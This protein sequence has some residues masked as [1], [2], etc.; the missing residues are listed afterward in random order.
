MPHRADCCDGA[1]EYVSAAGCVDNCVDVGAEWRAEQQE[2]LRIA[3]EGAEL[4]K[5]YIE[6]GQAA[7][8]QRAAR[9]AE[10]KAKLAALEAEKEVALRVQES[11]EA[12]EEEE[13]TVA[14]ASTESDLYAALGIDTMSAE[15]LRNL[16]VAHVRNTNTSAELVSYLKEA[17]GEAAEAAKSPEDAAEDRRKEL[18]ERDEEGEEAGDTPATPATPTGVHWLDNE[19]AAKNHVRPEAAA[20][21]ESVEAVE[22]SI[23]DVETE[24]TKLEASDKHDYGPNEEF[25]NLADHCYELGVAQYTYKVC[26]FGSAK[27]DHTSLGTFEG[28]EDGYKRMAFKNGQHC[29]NGPSRSMT[30]TFKCGLEEAILSVDEPSTCT[31]TAVMA[32]PAA[33]GGGTA[34]IGADGSVQ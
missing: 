26:P 11:E 30:V 31:Y 19:E 5:K 14:I 27:Q 7:K 16:L 17:K 13:R 25:F 6:A 20:A 8:I 2:A 15:E 23:R 3:T 21:R 4:Q 1:D 29:W 10:H 22:N 18:D 33:C 34:E 9:V 32:T 12:I 24:I 28:W